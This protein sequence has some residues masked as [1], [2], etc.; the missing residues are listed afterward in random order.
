MAP[1]VNTPL[2]PKRP[3]CGTPSFTVCGGM[4]GCQLAE[5]TACAANAMNNSTTATL[6]NTITLLKLADSLIPTTS[7]VVT[8]PMMITAGRLKTAA[9]CVPSGQVTIVPRAA[10]RAHGTSM[11]KSC[12]NDTTYPDQPIA[13]VTAPSAYSSTRSQPMIQAMSSPSVAYP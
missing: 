3:G 4:N 11:C 12:R 10:E 13:T 2:H 5:L 9:T 8:S 6:M 7:S 1:P